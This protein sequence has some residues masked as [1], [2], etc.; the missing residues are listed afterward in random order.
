LLEGDAGNIVEKWI[1]LAK[2]GKPLAM[3]LAVERLL[4]VRAA[5]DRVVELEGMPA[6]ERAAD[7]PGAV[8]SVI[9]RAAAGE[10]TLS[11]AREFMVLIE[12]ARR[13]I[14]TAD[15]SVRLEALEGSAAGKAQP[16]APVGFV[17][18]E[19]VPIDT[20]LS[21]RVRRLAPPR[22]VK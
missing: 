14:E 6:L 3:K 1:E 10:I 9:Q 20:S 18:A 4:P 7:L 5:R 15:L 8:A 16:G 11:E 13:A 22:E 21:A 12:Q 17:P 2:A 19:A